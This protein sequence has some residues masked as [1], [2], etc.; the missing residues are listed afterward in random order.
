MPQNKHKNLTLLFLRR[1]DE[2]LLAMKLRGFGVNRWNGVGG[3]LE[4]GESLDA[5]LVREAQEEIGITPINYQK[6]A[7]LHFN[8]YHNGQPAFMHVHVFTA[9]E[10]E[11]EPA[12]SEEMDPKWFDL[13][14]VPYDDMWPDD[15]YWLPQVLDGQKLSAN[16]TLDENDMIT[17]HEVKIEGSIG[18][19]VELQPGE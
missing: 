3:K 8:E 15:P 6:V 4:E 10:W 17:S 2:V 9:T 12:A 18:P 7:D 14:D 5:A 19:S 13:E 11:G 16:F 1:N